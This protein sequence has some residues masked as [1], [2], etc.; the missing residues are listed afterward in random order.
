MQS[1]ILGFTVAKR[2]GRFFFDTL[3]LAHRRYAP[4]PQFSELKP[5]SAHIL[6]FA[7][8]TLSSENVEEEQGRKR[9]DTVRLADSNGATTGNGSGCMSVEHDRRA[10]PLLIFMKAPC[11]P[12]VDANSTIPLGFGRGKTLLTSR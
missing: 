8:L 5:G 1:P 2:R 3:A 4:R 6:E 10:R 11:T 7:P 9:P 12:I